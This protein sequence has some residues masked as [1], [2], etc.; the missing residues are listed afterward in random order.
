MGGQ[1]TTALTYNPTGSVATLAMPTGLSFSYTYDAA[2]R[3][4][5]WSNNRGEQGSFT[6]DA[7]GNRVAEQIRDSPGAVAWTT[8]RSINKLNRIAARTDGPNQTMGFGY[9][10]NGEL[11]TETN[12]LS[13]S[14]RYGLEIA[15]PGPH[16]FGAL[17]FVRNGP[18]WPEPG[19][20]GF[21][22]V[23]WIGLLRPSSP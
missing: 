13:Q 18:I 6:L 7:M 16:W 5:G 1:Q 2:H 23:Q 19:V 11:I 12:G 17:A 3:L 4:T 21:E 22:S 15:S 9:G 8:A 10:A 14:T 20:S